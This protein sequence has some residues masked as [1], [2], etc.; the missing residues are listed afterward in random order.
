MNKSSHNL[1]YGLWFCVFAYALFIFW[2]SSISQVPSTGKALPLGDKLFHFTLYFFF[3]LLICLAIRYSW[4]KTPS[5]HII[6]FTLF[7][8]VFYALTDELHQS[9]V[10]A[11]DPSIWDVVADGVGGFVGA[12]AASS[13]WRKRHV[14]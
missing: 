8:V 5:G 12:L 11:R 9:F 13:I 4:Q 3:G 6:M 2:L 1:L 10:R 14:G 7:V